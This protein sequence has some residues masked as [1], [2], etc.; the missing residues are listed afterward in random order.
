MIIDHDITPSVSP[1]ALSPKKKPRR[2]KA[3]PA[4]IGVDAPEPVVRVAVLQRLVAGLTARQR[5]RRSAL[6]PHCLRS[7]RIAAFDHGFIVRAE[8]D[9]VGDGF[10][11]G[12]ERHGCATPFAGQVG[13][14]PAGVA[15]FGFLCLADDRRHS[16]TRMRRCEWGSVVAS[17]S[18]PSLLLRANRLSFAAT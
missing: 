13:L 11:L 5:T 9:N 14:D 10:I 18:P 15:H 1:A 8:A 4:R 3:Q 6:G 17:P 2:L 16:P 7:R 12:G